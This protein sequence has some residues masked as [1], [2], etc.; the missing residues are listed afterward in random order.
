MD[1]MKIGSALLLG[2]MVVMIWPRAKVMITQSP[3]GSASD[4]KAALF[5]I[6]MVVLFV[7][8]LISIV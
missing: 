5:P 4:W 2:A 7:L 3:K 1:W 6:V 8:F